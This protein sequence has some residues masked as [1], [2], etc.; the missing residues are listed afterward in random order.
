MNL[1]ELKCKLESTGLPVA[2]REWPEGESPGLPFIAYLCKDTN[3]V[4]SDN[5]YYCSSCV[6]H[7]DYSFISILY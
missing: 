2:Y 7:V 4:F 6:F 1:E 3:G 5:G